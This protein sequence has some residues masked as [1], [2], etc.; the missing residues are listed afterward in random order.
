MGATPTARLYLAVALFTMPQFQAKCDKVLTSAVSSYLLLGVVGALDARP[1]FVWLS[2][3]Q[4][5]TRKLDSALS[6]YLP[7]GAALRVR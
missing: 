2:L 1:G 7:C 3:K 6:S 4:S 5:V